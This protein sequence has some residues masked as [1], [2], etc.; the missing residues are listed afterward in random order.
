ML[1]GADETVLAGGH[2]HVPLVRRHGIHTLV[3]PGS[4]GLPFAQYGYAGGVA[5]L[6]HAAYAIMTVSRGQM[7][8]DLRQVDVDAAAL[9]A[10]VAQS[11]MPRAEWWL[12]LRNG[13]D[14]GA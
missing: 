7:N 12:G 6:A 4:V 9:D 8:I 5:V 14:H 2:T 10:R 1:D 11:G 13:P 3:N